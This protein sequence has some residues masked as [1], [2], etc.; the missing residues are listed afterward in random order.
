MTPASP[1]TAST[2]VEVSRHDRLNLEIKAHH[3]CPDA[4]VDTSESVL[5]VYWFIPNA[6]G[7]N[8]ASFQAAEYYADLRAHTR[9]MTPRVSLA[10][11]S[12]TTGVGSPLASL[13]TLLARA[14]AGG[15]STK[16]Q[17]GVRHEA[18]MVVCIFRRA[19]RLE[20]EALLACEDEAVPARAQALADDCQ[21]LLETYRG[22]VLRFEDWGV[23]D[24]T[25]FTLQACDE[26]LSVEV[27]AM[28]SRIVGAGGARLGSAAG[29][30]VALAQDERWQRTERGDRSAASPD[31]KD[32]AEQAAFWDQASLLKKFVAQALFLTP[33]KN[34]DAKR[35]EH[36]AKAVAAA[37]AM[38]WTVSLQVTS[39]FLL[40]L[41]LTSGVDLRAIILFSVV[42]V[43]GYILKDRIKDTVGRRLAASIPRLLYDRRLDLFR[44][45]ADEPLGQVR[46]RVSF[47]DPDDL[48][49]AVEACRRR[50][51]R[52]AVATRVPFDALH[53]QRRVTAL[54]RSA[55]QSFAR[56]NGLTD[57]LR[58]NLLSWTR[59]LDARRKSIVVLD[60]DG[61]PR[62]VQ[63]PN[64]Y[65]V[66]LVIQVTDPSGV[67]VESWRLALTRR[68]L[69]RVEAVEGPQATT[70]TAL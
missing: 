48:P 12:R 1:P 55:A 70:E 6:V 50:G 25:R 37:L 32:P 46:E 31:S 49:A 27:E 4:T 14:P 17:R 5:D 36:V 26:A 30:L 29:A 41:E 68:G 66:D 35:L 15:P 53:Y 59:T 18:R 8:P 57:I 54:P 3:R 51:V 23:E 22:L 63:V 9:L 10:E 61:R 56:M 11:L 34:G 7:V 19:V 40:G 39:I 47:V 38:V 45:D 24:A 43:L 58:L 52:A 42:A 28:A 21:R 60:G 20:A 44:R 2:R 69:Q 16:M 65:F 33:R 64:H 13:G 67:R 62:E